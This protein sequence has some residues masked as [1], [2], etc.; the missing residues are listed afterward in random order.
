[1]QTPKFQ[2]F[3]HY[4]N[5]PYKFLGVAKH[6]ETLEELAV[7]ET[8]YQNE[9]S[10][11]WVRPKDMFFEKGLFQGK[12]QLRFAPTEITITN[13]RQPPESNHWLE[14]FSE[15]FPD[16][17]ELVEKMN[18]KAEKAQVWILQLNGEFAG[19]KLGRTKDTSTFESWLGGIQA[20]LRHRGLGLR[21]MEAQHQDLETQGFQRVLTKCLNTN[22]SMI[23]LNLE[24][25]FMITGTEK[26]PRGLKLV[27]EKQLNA[28]RKNS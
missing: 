25:G 23:K 19:F 12:E 21:L 14:L 26:S 2:L 20:S 3:T 22:Q 15:L 1:M 11:L 28:A 9:L 16:K 6:S 4:K 7:Y 18:W 17:A 10:T 24:A 13:S 8:L 5:K 27:L